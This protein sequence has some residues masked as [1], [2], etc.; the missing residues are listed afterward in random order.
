MPAVTLVNASSPLSF[1]YLLCAST[2][3]NEEEQIIH[4]WKKHQDLGLG[5]V[6]AIRHPKRANEV[7]KLVKNA[8][9]EYVLHSMRP[10]NARSRQVYI[11]DTLGELAPFMKNATIVFIGGSLVPIGGHN[12]LEPARLGRCTLIGHH[13]QN[14]SQIVNELQ[15]CKGV[16]VVETA[17]DLFNQVEKLNNDEKTRTSM[18]KNA[19]QYVERKQKILEKYTQALGEFMQHHLS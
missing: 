14:F 12:I 9:M 4:E 6:I 19:R 10:A 3:A 11:I 2:H 18:Q 17:R 5:L 7:C 8:G 13:H 1:S 15:D 16:V